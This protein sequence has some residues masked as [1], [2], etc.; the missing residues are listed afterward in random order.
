[1]S[2]Q[3]SRK[4]SSSTTQSRRSGSRCTRESTTSRR[5]PSRST[6]ATSASLRQ[7][8]SS[9]QRYVGLESCLICLIPHCSSRTR[10]SPPRSQIL[11]TTSS[12]C[13][14]SMCEEA[15]TRTLCSRVGQ[16]CLAASRDGSN[17]T[18]RGSLT[19]VSRSPS[20]FLV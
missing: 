9:T 19:S 18:S 6:S 7:R 12:R 3:T 2:R 20:S 11:W 4:S 15:S 17:G 1:M 13:A 8:S 14:Q 10:T 16:R 5:S